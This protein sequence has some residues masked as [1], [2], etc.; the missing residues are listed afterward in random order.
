MAWQTPKTDWSAADGV[1]NTDFNRIEGNIL[2]LKESGI[3]LENI[4]LYVS[5]SGSDTTGTGTSASPFASINKAVSVLPRN[6]NGKTVTINVAAGTYSGSTAISGFCGGRLCI[7]GTYLSNVTLQSSLVVDTSAII[8]ENITLTATSIT[9]TNGSDLICFSGILKAS[10]G[11]ISVANNS[12]AHI[13]EATV[14]NAITGVSV[15]NNSE[16][17]ISSLKGSGVTMGVSVTG[18]SRLGYSFNTLAASEVSIH[19]S[20]GGRVYA[21]AQTSVPNY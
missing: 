4:T 10:G 7:T 16:A 17:F 8:I 9:I 12:K 21:G 13:Y 5:P 6:L 18:G 15:G 3:V 14:Q 11:T 20:D 1:R 2:A 19:T